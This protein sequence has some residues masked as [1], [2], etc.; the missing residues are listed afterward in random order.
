MKLFTKENDN[1]KINVEDCILLGTTSDNPI[2]SEIFSV[3]RLKQHAETLAEA[4]TVTKDPTKGYDL[5][6]RLREN[7]RKLFRSYKSISEA[8][9]Q[10]E[11]ITSAA[12]W[13]IDNFHIIEEQLRDIR[14]HLPIWFYREL[15]KLSDGH[16]KAYPRVYGIAWAFIAHTDSR[17][18]PDLL[19]QFVRAYQTVQPLTI[20]EL[21]AIAITLRIVLIENLACLSIQVMNSSKARKSADH[22]ADGLLGLNGESPAL[23]EQFLYSLETKEL[24]ESFL[25]QLIQR[26][27]YQDP[28]ITPALGWLNKKLIEMNIS[29]DE[30]VSQ[31]HNHQS[32]ANLTVRNIITSMRLISAFEWRKFFQSVSLVNEV[33]STNP[34]FPTLDFITQDYY[35]HVIEDLSKGSKLTEI[36]LAKLIISKT[37][38]FKTVE[39]DEERKTEPGY[40][41]LSTGRKILEKE[42]KFRIPFKQRLEEFFMGNAKL[43]YFSDILFLTLFIVSILLYVSYESSV[44]IWGL[45]ALGFAAIVPTSDMVIALVNKLV[46]IFVGPKHLPRIKFTEVPRGLATFVV[47]PVLLINEKLNQEFLEQLE[48]H[49]LS[50]T[51]GRIHFALLTDWK[52]SDTESKP[53][54]RKLWQQ[55]IQGI[56]ELNNKY[57]HLEDGEKRFFVYHRKRLWNSSENKWMGWERK[58]GKLQEFNSLL[59]GAKNTSHIDLN[60]EEI[61]IPEAIKYVVTLDADTRMPIDLVKQLVGTMA[62]PLN[63]PR[64]DDKNRVIEGYGIMQPRVMASL[65]TR[66][67]SSIYQELFSGPCGI[68]PYTFA[69][70]D[71]YQDLFGEGSYIGK[72]IYDVDVFEK[73]LSGRV[74]EN[75][76][77]SHDLFEGNFARCGFV[78][79]LELFED[80]PSHT[81]VAAT[82]QD[83][84]VRGDW[85]LLPWILGYKF[86]SLIGRWKMIDNLRRSLSAPSMVATLVLAW[87]LPNAPYKLWTL[88]TLATLAVPLFIPL[89]SGFISY[90][91]N[92]KKLHSRTNFSYEFSISVK[93]LIFLTSQL[94]YQALHMCNT[95]IVT[96]YRTFISRKH[97]LQWVTAAQ[98]KITVNLNLSYFLLRHRVSVFL[99][100]II[101]GL[102]LAI[103]SNQDVESFGVSFIFLWI[104]SPLVAYAVSLPPPED[105]QEPLNTTEINTMRLYARRTWKFF[106]TFVTQED[107]LL[108]PDNFQEIPHPVIA[109]RSSPTNF[110]LYLLSILSAKEFG[111]IGVFETLKRLNGTLDVLQELP[112]YAGHFYNWYE[113]RHKQPLEPRYISSVDSGN[114]AGYLLVLAKTCED[115]ITEPLAV[116]SSVAGVKDV[117]KLLK[118]SIAKIK[119]RRRTFT[120][121]FDQLQ[122]SLNVL[123]E[124][125]ADI[126]QSPSGYID[127]WKLIYSYSN[128]LL[129]ISKT[130]VQEHPGTINNEILYWANQVNANIETH[131]NDYKKIFA[132]EKWFN[133]PSNLSNLTEREKEILDKLDSKDI[134]ELSLQELICYYHRFSE[135]LLKLQQHRS[136]EHFNDLISMLK[137]SRDACLNI[138]QQ[139][140]SISE[141]C[142]KL[143]NEMDFKFLYDPIRKLFSIGF[144]VSD[145]RLD[146][147]Y[148]DMLASE[149]R[150][151][152]FIAVAK[153]DV[154]VAHWFSLSRVLTN[155]HNE[156]TLL[157]WS[158]SMFEYLMPSLIMY[159]PRDSLLDKTCH[160]IIRKQIDYANKHEIPWGISE[161][162]YN[163]RD[164]NF[165]YQY[166]S[167]GIPGLGLKRGLDQN[168]VVS[169][170]STALAAMYYPRFALENFKKLVDEDILGS[171]GFYEAIDYTSTRIRENEDFSTIKAYMV[172]HQGMSLV[173]LANVVFNGVMRHRF[174]SIPKIKATEL[175]LQERTPRTVTLIQPKVGQMEIHNVRDLVQPAIRRFELPSLAIPSTHFLSNGHYSVMV[176]SAGSGYSRCNDIA[177]TRWREDPSTDIWGSYIFLRDIDTKQSWSMGYQP[178]A[179]KPHSYEVIFTEDKARITREDG[180]ILSVMD[181]VVSAED[182]AEI[183]KIS[184]RNKGN[185]TKHIELT[186]YSEIV[187]APQAADLMHPAFSNLFVQTE[188]IAETNT[189]IASRRPRSA[190]ENQIWLA[191]VIAIEGNHRS[192]IEYETDRT[193]FLGRGHNIR[194]AVSMTEYHPLSNT[195]GPVLDPIVSLRCKIEIP[196]NT[197]RHVSFSTVIANSRDEI[198]DLADK[199]HDPSIFDRAA[200]LAWAYSQVQLHYLGIDDTDANIFQQ[201]ANN[202]IY[203][204]PLMRPSNEILKRNVLDVTGLWKYQISGD[205][206]IILVYIDSIDDQGLIKQLLRAHEYLRLK[207]FAV[208]LVIV[209]EKNTSYVQ[210]LQIALEALVRTNIRDDGSSVGKAFVLRDDLLTAQENELL[211]TVARVV[212]SCKEGS[213]AEQVMR[214]K[215]VPKKLVFENRFNPKIETNHEEGIVN[216]SLDFF[217]GLG[218]FTKDGKEYVITLSKQQ[219]TP[220]P[221]INVIANEKIGFFVSESGSSYT[222][223]LNSRENQITPWSN[224]P[225]VDPSGEVFYIHDQET[226]ETWTP[227]AL[228]IRS[229][230]SR[231]LIQHGFGYSHFVHFNHGIK[232]TLTQFVASEDPVKIS[233]LI[234]ENY[235]T[236]VK[237]LSITAYIEWTLG[238]SRTTNA[239]FVITELDN[240]TKAIFAYNPWNRDFNKRI[241]FADFSGK[242]R[243]WTCDKKEFIGRN[244]SLQ[245]PAAIVF[246]SPLSGTLGAGLDPCAA[247][248]F[249]VIIPAETKVELCFFLGQVDDRENARALIE[250][251]RKINIEDALNEVKNKWNSVLGKVQVHS[252]DLATNILLNGWLLYQTLSCRYLAR[253][254][255]YQAGGAYGFRDQ[256]QDVLALTFAKPEL[257]KQQI[258]NA[259]HH[260]FPEGDVQHWWHPPNDK[261]VRTRCS[262][263]SIWLPFVVHHYIK[264][265]GDQEILNEMIPFIGGRELLP[266]EEGA[267]FEPVHLEEKATLFE[268]CKR[269]LDRSLAVGSHG[270]P[271]I[272]SCDW[273]DGMN[274][275]GHKG[276]GESVWLGWFLHTALVRFSTI[277]EIYGDN[278]SAKNWLEHAEKLKKSLEDEAWDGSWYKRAFFDDGTPLG[279]SANAECRIDSIAQSWSVISEVANRDRAI[280]AMDSVNQHLVKE[281]DNLVLLFTPPF[282]KTPLDPGYIKGYLPGIRENGSQY[283]HAA[284]WTVIAFAIL[285]NGNKA[286]ELFSMLNPINH[287]S[288]R[289][290]VYKYKVEPYVMPADIYSE[291]PHVGRGGWTWYTG[292]AGWMYRAGL[293]W[294]LGLNIEKNH[295]KFNPNIPDSWHDYSLSYQHGQSK[296]EITVINKNHNRQGIQSIELDDNKLEDFTKGIELIDDAK[297]HLVKVVI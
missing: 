219:Y 72:G 186:S 99:A 182:N 156:A 71:I 221:W 296:Y 234:L 208:D 33:L 79:D 2:R 291:P 188:Y 274:M 59:R 255:F 146:A 246:D 205:N 290:G 176:S 62:H 12:E 284:V 157:S 170:Y 261:G 25:V 124:S 26:L 253:T 23:A 48:V 167:F 279:S 207:K 270:L 193:R 152:S 84:W 162:A 135:D 215:Q 94:L 102:L 88:F 147:S 49:Y 245:N 22:I 265:S 233:R 199:Y 8:V 230:T 187:L 121:D 163:I 244:G 237:Q 239:P 242:Q 250:K 90:S 9:N 281:G 295:L 7:R 173:A 154:P 247:Q 36:E 112:R 161:S 224:D 269:I 4:Q 235:S 37:E 131:L 231:Y 6:K 117:L 227:T 85:Q 136:H 119:D 195:V 260:Q 47:M 164:L 294:I 256:L 114:L 220:T 206:P 132:W 159:T 297:V 1:S 223:S 286:F 110:G 228:P 17:F 172:H 16:L 275:V 165:T 50:N 57:G 127:Q 180:D 111:W 106:T 40:Y 14:E 209:N 153:G 54:D 254:A 259:A 32:A 29:A 18:D 229:K 177:I 53:D 178:S 251:Y 77:L 134:F 225:I 194:K 63:K 44:P 39:A 189:L 249:T 69:S 86:M 175:L 174:H 287:A 66:D 198:I 42:I 283:T 288:S 19:I 65:P 160:S 140:T 118:E 38:S 293:E 289:A 34:L 93:Q 218:G 276:L 202:I 171:Y 75:A 108:P 179:I 200:S 143:F 181:I 262:D 158:G 139:L 67:N 150:L 107:N 89:I 128:T 238:S 73:A 122:N 125:L 155:I 129:D 268:H 216:P 45:V 190:K 115:I 92:R 56:E 35:L 185:R 210:D 264:V 55:V 80:F 10:K 204:N 196:P 52:D 120:V 144:N 226:G 236:K 213:L 46:M 105:P 30:L 109:H 95:I 168:L 68:D 27:R 141:L 142:M 31:E 51:E 145:N 252:P 222:W 100:L 248:N 192:A 82:R 282:D 149:A 113:L 3:D 151:T 203:V 97:L 197:T 184:I 166:S 126:P 101:G 263:D 138:R 169:P 11:S 103:K 232:S 87:F 28:E 78:S 280:Q 273:N 201:L 148:Y 21:W 41:L 292:S 96:L 130:F 258:I 74:P 83:R 267:Y 285:G 20:G 64:F 257:I 116:N 183:R 278:D 5:N 137:E 15:P 60:N 76:L 211:Q 240:Q 133:K 212:L 277:A 98:T 271:F 61:R 191:H 91:G 266:E 272:G 243:S 70:S 13:L 104:I 43:G 24:K 217:N 123:E 81:E 58:R 241:S 214:I